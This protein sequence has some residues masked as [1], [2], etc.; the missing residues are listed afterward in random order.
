[1]EDVDYTIL[2]SYFNQSPKNPKFIKVVNLSEIIFSSSNVV[3]NMS[4]ETSV[5]NFKLMLKNCGKS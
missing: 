1:M 3:F 2:S 4:S 5:Q